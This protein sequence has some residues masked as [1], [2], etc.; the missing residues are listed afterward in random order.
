MTRQG[1]IIAV[2]IPLLPRRLKMMEGE[3][4]NGRIARHGWDMP[5]CHRLALI[6]IMM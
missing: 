1:K 5:H 2:N 3:I 4:P 6:Q